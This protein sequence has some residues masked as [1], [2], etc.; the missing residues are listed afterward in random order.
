MATWILFCTLW[1]GAVLVRC[2]LDDAI[3]GDLDVVFYHSSHR[4]LR[5]MHSDFHLLV[6]RSHQEDDHMDET[7]ML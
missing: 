1:Q 2:Q 4:C 5:R 6:V 7:V 3:D